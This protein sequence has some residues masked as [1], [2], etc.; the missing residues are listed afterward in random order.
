MTVRGVR[1]LDYDGRE[2]DF[3]GPVSELSYAPDGVAYMLPGS[4]E[5]SKEVER[6]TRLASA[7]KAEGMQVVV[8]QGL[9]F[10]GA[11]MASIVAHG[12]GKFVIGLQRPSVRSYWKIPLINSA[13]TPVE[14]EDPKVEQFIREA[15]VAG[16]FTATFVDEAMSLADVVVSD[17]QCDV[18]KL[19][20]GDSSKA[21][22]EIEAFIRATRT[23]A[24]LI[25]PNALYL[26]ETTVPP[27]TTEFIVRP[28]FTEEYRRRTERDLEEARKT[29]VI[30][31]EFLS[32]FEDQ[33]Q[34]WLQRPDKK[35]KAELVELA[36]TKHQPRIAHSYERVM[37]GREYVDSVINFPRVFSGVDDTAAELAHSFLSSVLTGPKAEL[38]RL[39]TPTDSEF[40]KC[41]ENTYRATIIALGRVL[42]RTA[43]VGGVDLSKVV[44]AIKKRPTHRDMLVPRTPSTGGY[45]LPKDPIFIVWSVTHMPQFKKKLTGERAVQLRHL[46][47]FIT[48]MVDINDTDG[49]HAVDMM[50]DELKAIGK[51]LKGARI[52]VAGASYREDVADTRYA[53]YEA[54]VRYLQ[55]RGAKI[56]VTD[57][58]VKSLPELEQQGEDPYSMA[59]HFKKQKSLTKLKVS[60]DLIEA[61]KGADGVIFAIPHEPYTKLTPAD[62]ASAIGVKPQRF[63][64]VDCGTFNG[65]AFLQL[66]DAGFRIRKMYHGR[67]N[68]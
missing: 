29:G 24:E 57:P 1:A 28:I 68:P 7:A 42:G 20:F 52:V 6:V 56:A 63:V 8:V 66:V 27:G 17:V 10:V 65:S 67:V 11:I 18:K 44:E 9:G 61:L 62:I 53:P 36:L 59:K 47:R 39:P 45:C 41:A 22:V 3:R 5:A 40:S 13:R 35:A 32:G 43:E 2:V 48:L 50:K 23:V 60:S 14:S 21:T 16:R 51:N 15:V 38:T 26:V 55:E 58:Y 46:L 37:P 34:L 12:Q 49:M 33:V 19:R 31:S 4:R 54:I 64:I 25:R 30:R